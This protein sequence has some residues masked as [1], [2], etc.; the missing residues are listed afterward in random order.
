ME[1]CDQRGEPQTKS[2]VIF[3]LSNLTYT[4]RLKGKKDSCDLNLTT[5][6]ESF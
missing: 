1:G 5:S 3:A 6:H 2:G 4:N